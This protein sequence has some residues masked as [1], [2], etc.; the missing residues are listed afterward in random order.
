MLNS[1]LFSFQF[2]KYFQQQKIDRM[3]LLRNLYHQIQQVLEYRSLLCQS[4]QQ[5]LYVNLLDTK[6]MYWIY[7]GVRIISY[8]HLLWI[9][10][11]DYGMFLETIVFALFNI[12]ISLRV[13]ISIRKMIDSSYR[14]LWIVNFDF[15]M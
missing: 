8:Y 9:K 7:L 10:L 4:F 12:L 13:S 1:C 2:G 5:N 3:P 6:M 14:V 15:G 11:F